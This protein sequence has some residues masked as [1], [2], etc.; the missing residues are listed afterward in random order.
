MLFTDNFSL[1]DAHSQHILKAKYDRVDNP[2]QKTDRSSR[3]AMS[4]RKG[5]KY[6]PIPIF[7]LDIDTV[8]MT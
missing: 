7:W 5:L 6:R 2:G 4:F 8:D 3:L 1:F